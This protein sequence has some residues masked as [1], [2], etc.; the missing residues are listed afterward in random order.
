MHEVTVSVIIPTY[1]RAGYLTEAIESVLAQTYKDIEII[2]VDDGSDDNTREKLSPYMDRI[3]Y[4]YIENGG[5]ARAR[6]VGMK[7]ARGKYIAFL[8]S[9][10]CYYPHKI[11]LQAGFLDKHGDVALICS[12]LSAINDK[13]IL[14]EFHLK[15]YHKA[16][17]L[18]EEATYEKIYSKS[19]SI[20]DA[21]FDLEK[22]GDRKIYVGDVFDRYYNELI[23]S[24][25][26]VMFRKSVLES[27]GFQH[28]PYWLFEDYDFILRIVKSHRVAFIDAPTYKL[29]YHDA[30]ISSTRK[31]PNGPEI[32]IKKH[33]NLIE[34]A[35]KY[36]F[37]DNDY[38][39]RNKAAVDKRLHWLNRSLAI[40]LMKTRSSSRRARTHLKN[41]AKFNRP[42]HMLW[43]LTLAPYPMRLITFKLSALLDLINLS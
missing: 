2:V 26:T 18:N 21:G 23:L 37:S 8:D 15:N 7:M 22:W 25:N 29:R 13:K 17:Y 36:G 30:Q 42:E 31:K 34:I 4:V 35:E 11:E 6:N 20:A 3:K 1:N 14:D 39:A 40:T 27:V 28:E 41:C 10:D 12:D 9:D 38:Y 16:A 43:L 32:L 5:P 24:T 19:V 33:I